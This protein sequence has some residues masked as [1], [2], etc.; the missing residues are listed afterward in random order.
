MKRRQFV[1]SAPVLAVST[2]GATALAQTTTQPFPTKLITIYVPYPAGGISDQQARTIAPHLSKALGQ[3]VV[4]ENLTGAG[5]SIAAQKMLSSPA[6]GHSLMVVSPNE[7]ILAPLTITG[8]KY[9]AE[10]FRLLANGVAAPTALLARSTL[11]ADNVNELLA[12]SANKELRYGSVGL[13]SMPHLTAEDF[14]QRTG[15]RLLHVP[16]RGGAPMMQDMMAGHIDIAFMA[17]AGPI[18]GMVA[19]GKIKI[20]GVAAAPRI[21]ALAQFAAL[22]DHAALRDFDYPVWST[23]AVSKSVP[24][25]TAAK[26]NQTINDIMQLPQVQAWVKSAGSF[27][28]EPVT[29]QGAADFYQTET[30]K[31][32]RLAKTLN[33][34]AP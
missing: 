7:T 29:L 5:G 22:N 4:I 9:Q 12:Y 16:Y 11:E 23:F 8:L 24:E 10:D 20:I 3:S 13:G 14:R 21:P 25:E 26:L 31:I 18:L 32:L 2:L 1:L 34:A 15:A 19:G 17:F 30:R 33:L 27:V 28:L 6:D